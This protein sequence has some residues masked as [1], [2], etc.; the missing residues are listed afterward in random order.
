[1][2]ASARV[3]VLDCWIEINIQAKRG[4]ADRQPEMYRTVALYFES[5]IDFIGNAPLCAFLSSSITNKSSREPLSLEGDL[6]K[7]AL[8]NKGTFPDKH[9]TGQSYVCRVAIPA[10]TTASEN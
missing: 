10:S 2:T 6:T 3:K 4:D 7:F 8:K 1:M 5:K 9:P